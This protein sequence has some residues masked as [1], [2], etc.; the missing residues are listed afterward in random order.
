M[1]RFSLL[2]IVACNFRLLIPATSAAPKSPD[3]WSAQLDE[4]DIHPCL[5]FGPEDIP[6]MRKRLD[7][8]PYSTWWASVR[9]RRDPVSLAFVWLMTGDQEAA[10]EAR[11]RL[12]QAYPSGYHCACGVATPLQGCA[13][14]YDLLYS[15]EGLSP[16]DH[17]VIQNS[18]A[19]ACERMFQAALGSGAGQHPGN[20]RTRG[21]CALGTAAMVLRSYNDAAHTPRQWLQQALDSLRQE[22]NLIFWRDDGMFIEGPIYSSFTLSIMMPFARYYEQVTGKWIFSEPRLHQALLY[23]I[24]ITQPDG[25]CAPI[26]TTNSAGVVGSLRLCVGAG[27]PRIQQACRWAIDEWS[28]PRGGG[29]REIAM[30]DNRVQ[31]ALGGLAPS[32]FFPTTREG[33]LR[34]AWS[35]N[36]VTLWFKGKE[37]WLAETQ[38]IYSHADTTSFVL[39]AY[40]EILAVDAGYDHWVSKNL[41]PPQLHNTLLVDGKGPTETTT[42][43]LDH[44]LDAG[45]LQAGD[46][47]SDYCGIHHRRTFS[48]VD[49]TYVVIVDDINATEPHQYTWQIHTPVT[50]KNHTITFSGNRASWTGFDPPS[51]SPGNVAVEAVWA[52]PVELQ[53]LDGSRWQPFK[54]DPATGSYDNWALG[55]RKTA[56][57]TRFLTVLYPHPKHLSP[58]II[59]TP[60]VQGGRCIIVRRGSR[61]DTCLALD[62]GAASMTIGPITNTARTC[63]LRQENGTPIFAYIAG[64]GRLDYQEKTLIQTTENTCL[65]GTFHSLPGQGPRFV[66]TPHH[67]APGDG[68]GL[69]IASVIIDG[70]P[71]PPM[72]RVDLGKQPR[73][74]G[75]VALRV[76]PPQAVGPS[77]PAIW[78][79]TMDGVRLPP[80]RSTVKDG[81]IIVNLPPVTSPGRHE[82]VL[83]LTDW[84]HPWMHGQFLLSFDTGPLLANGDFEQGGKH[85][86]DWSLG[87]WSRDARTQYDIRAVRDKPHSGQWCLMMQGRAGALN[88]VAA[89]RVDV[90]LGT[91]YLVRGFVRGDVSAQLSFCSESGKGQYLWS[92]PFG[93]AAD[94]L[95]FS[96][97]FTVENPEEILFLAMRLGTRGTVYF[98]DLSL[99]EI[100]DPSPGNPGSR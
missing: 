77:R 9:S 28:S 59:E 82:L 4:K 96:W 30:F 42:G 39:H 87:A 49:G 5:M 55:A 34:R 15:Y 21:A 10:E 58:A 37:P 65:T 44:D 97:K 70:K 57:S 98:D 69:T 75:S 1:T 84:A 54:A 2:L 17:R 3:I 63:I 99:K 78:T 60:A 73:A 56:A 95:P 80:T 29:V 83:C 90:K 71:V 8:K 81:Q 25:L 35:R 100:P 24:S 18:L 48:L 40:G 45:F 41:Y 38:S 91:T 22:A 72:E 16:F 6:A 94:W 36:A 32:R 46:I 89:Q 12:L 23:L 86:R 26:G 47:V 19:A 61:R 14:A 64:P 13:E 79:R 43:R 92:P 62:P 31:P 67:Q 76:S 20:Q 88:I 11:V 50:R 52:G 33:H 27:N 93:P 66:P 85:P 51:D 74:P 7:R 53:P 68:P